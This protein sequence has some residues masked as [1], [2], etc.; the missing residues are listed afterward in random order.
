MKFSSLTDAFRS[1][2]RA[3]VFAC[4]LGLL[5]QSSQGQA[6]WGMYGG[7]PQHTAISS[8]ASQPLQSI[9][10]QTPVDLNPQYSGDDLL[11]HY[12]SPIVTQAN[13]VLVPVKTGAGGG[14]RIEAHNGATGALLWSTDSDYILP[15]HRWVPS[16]APTLTPSGR[17]YFAG[18]GGTVYWRD[19][20][21]SFTPGTLHQIAFYGTTNYNANKP[22]YDDAVRICTPL[23]ADAN[24]NIYFGYRVSAANPLNLESGFARIGADGSATFN[25]VANISPGSTQI[26]MNCAPAVS[27][28]G[29]TVYIATRDGNSHGYLVAL[30]TLTLNPTARVLLKDAQN[31]NDAAL[32]DDGTASPLVAP[33]GKVFFGVLENPFRTF[34]GWLLQ[35]TADLSQQLT[36][37]AFGWDDTPSV[38]PASMVPS[39]LGTSPYLLLCKYNNYVQ[40]GGDG[41]NK[42]AV[43]DPNDT[44]TDART[45]ATVMKEILTIAGV[46]PDED[47][48]NSPGA[49]REWCINTAAID[50]FTKS[51]LVNNED[52]KLYR[53][54]LTTNT[55][56]QQITLTSGIGEAYTPTIIGRDGKVY[57]INNAVLFA[58]GLPNV[59][60]SGTVTLQG[61]VNPAQTVQFTFTP[62]AGMPFTRTATLT[63][64]GGYSL[65]NIPAGSYTLKVKGDKW[66]SRSISLNATANVSNADLLLLAGDA[67]GDNFAD[68]SDLLLLV[69]HYNQIAP[70]AGYLDAVDFTCDGTVDI[71]DLLLL[72]GNYN[73][74][75]N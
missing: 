21:D 8:V 41:V 46:T 27:N 10:W 73:Q 4:G 39:Y 45:G 53:W 3:M 52:G 40:A 1:G 47:F 28:N 16:Y 9:V 34:R 38:V 75:G 58:L 66:L 44:Q 2:T 59:T 55:F 64:T 26:V 17:L 56:T 62:S 63:P 68:I 37:G 25:S 14:F 74:Q 60:V 71:T 19:N 29:S 42:L 13:T 48:P 43:L 11:I 57:A 35:F 15:G 5:A 69:T 67:N 70:A 49:V 12:G 22:T 20:L 18:T 6:F 31:G 72:I 24:G 54:D 50:P 36:A 51:A 65:T 23:T 61:C 33:D 7:N 30:N 32:F